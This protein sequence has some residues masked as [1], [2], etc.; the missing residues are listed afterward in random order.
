ME[1]KPTPSLHAY[2]MPH[3]P[4]DLRSIHP[5]KWRPFNAHAYINIAWLRTSYCGTLCEGS[6]QPHRCSPTR[7]SFSW[8]FLCAARSRQTCLPRGRVLKG[9]RWPPNWFKP[10]EISPLPQKG[11]R[12]QQTG[13]ATASHQAGQRATRLVNA[14]TRARQGLELCGVLFTAKPPGVGVALCHWPHAQL[15]ARSR[16][17][18]KLFFALSFLGMILNGRLKLS[19]R[20]E[21]IEQNSV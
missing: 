21:N 20:A 2:A 12:G 3:A 18:H 13:Q 6:A 7:C 9:P 5:Y 17:H 14:A 4:D 8:W 15:L 1:K 11:N 19:I 16:G 10:F